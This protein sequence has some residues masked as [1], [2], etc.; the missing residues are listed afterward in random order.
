MASNPKNITDLVPGGKKAPKPS[1]EN[2]DERVL[3]LLGLEGFEVEMDYDT[4][5]FA[6]RE[7]MTGGRMG[8]SKYPSSEVEL[9]T[10][11]WKRVKRKKGRFKKKVKKIQA[12]DIKK[13]GA[14]GTGVGVKTTTVSAQKLLPGTAEESPAIG[15]IV[16]SLDNIAGYLKAENKADKKK[17][18]QDRKQS[19]RSRRENMLGGLKKGAAKI[20][21][22]ADKIISPVKNILQRILEWFIKIVLARAV[23]KLLE[24]FSD[25]SNEGKVNTVFRFIKDWWPALLGGYILFGTSFGGFI[26]SL[27]PMLVGWTVKLGALLAANPWLLAAAGVGVGIYGIGKMLGK[28]KVVENETER[29]NISRE[30]LEKAPSTKDLTPGDREALVQGTRIRDAGG[31]GSLN[32]MRDIYN[33]PLGLRQDPTGMGGMGGMG[34]P[35]LS[36]GG[37][38]DGFVS[39]DKG[40][41]KVPAMLTDGEFVMSKG[42]VKKYGTG[43]LEA[44]NAAGG[45][46]NRP[47]MVSGTVFAQGGGQLGKGHDKPQKKES[48]WT[49]GASAG[50]TGEEKGVK[51]KTTTPK[52]PKLDV[53]VNK[54]QGAMRWLAGAADYVTGGWFDFDKRG[55]GGADII[56]AAKRLHNLLT[57]QQNKPE[58]KDKIPSGTVIPKVKLGPPRNKDG[59]ISTRIGKNELGDT[60]MEQWAK[61]FPHLAKNVKKRTAVDTNTSQQLKLIRERAKAESLSESGNT[62][63][64]EQGKSRLNVLLAV[65]PN[66]SDY[67]EGKTGDSE[68]KIALVKWQTSRSAK[69]SQDQSNFK[70][71]PPAPPSLSVH[72]LKSSASNKDTSISS[73]I[74]TVK[75]GISAP[76]ISASSGET[77]STAQKLQIV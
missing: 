54:P 73:T 63:L 12:K 69:M 17:A 55:G 15:N 18:E 4:Y 29:A 66:R 50:V 6:L 70:K 30:A 46:T 24:W 25:P 1:T 7:F 52:D 45:G 9:V 35:G 14:T 44:M 39:G 31:G 62:Q 23:I 49:L 71:A 40:V 59:S 13:G 27:I 8:T 68:Y 38:F 56:E 41:D 19:V 65:K 10:N 21:K 11:E 22:V 43:T 51:E 36:G 53:N 67:G 64:A 74:P 57:N 48:L 77:G 32:N 42:A 5:R 34:M 16:E 72:K 3:R 58:K 61:N 75:K 47:K 28:D 20:A 33:D 60:P 26:T 76:T 37:L 2:I